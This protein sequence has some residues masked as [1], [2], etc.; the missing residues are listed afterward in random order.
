MELTARLQGL[1][2]ERGLT[3]NTIVQGLWAVLLGRLTGRDD[4]VFGVTVSGRPAELAG[5]EQMVGLFINTLPLRVRL[6]RGQPLAVLLAGIQESQA[7]LLAHQHVGLAEIQRAA[8]SGTLFDTL[9]VFENYPLDHA[10]LA[11]PV[12]GLRLAGVAGAGCDALS[13][14]PGGHA[15]RT[16]APAA[17][18]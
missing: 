5:I 10:A 9:V 11:E 16:A 8:G 4:V 14:E 17:G 12:E 3:L 15:R 1:A 2:R 18:L 13:V 7:R 6:R